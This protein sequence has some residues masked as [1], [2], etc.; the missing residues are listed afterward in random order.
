MID[1]N[2]E[3]SVRSETSKAGVDPKRIVEHGLKPGVISAHLNLTESTVGPPPGRA[4]PPV[5]PRRSIAPRFSS[6]WYWI[7]LWMPATLAC[8]SSPTKT[9]SKPDESPAS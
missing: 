2:T 7:Q 5:H 6:R 4:S 3:K 8:D 9:D 1:S